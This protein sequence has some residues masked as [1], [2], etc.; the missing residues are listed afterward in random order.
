[1]IKSLLILNIL[2]LVNNLVTSQMAKLEIEGAIQIGN[3]EDPI[4][5]PGTIR[6]TGA[7]F[8]GWNGLSWVSL[9]GN[10]TVGSVTDIEGNTYRTIRVG[11]Q[12]WMAENLRVTRF[13]DNNSIEQIADGMIWSGLST[14][15]WCWY[16]NDQN[17]ELPY[18]KLYNWYAVATGKLCPT[19]WHV[20][21]SADWTTLIDYLGGEDIAGGKIK[22]TG[23][24]HWQSPNTGAT[25]ESSLTGLP[26][27]TRDE[28]GTY[29]NIGSYGIWWSSTASSISF[30]NCRILYSFGEKILSS[31][32][33]KVFGNSVRCLKD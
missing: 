18:G 13:S 14:P 28:N 17:Y 8:E 10:A 24:S 16:D 6:W 22:E 1:M 15:A 32:N 26:G 2:F 30:A 25:N 27:G 4:P 3:L 20:P 5:H 12:E 29:V 21:T 7:D 19:G 11:D 23:L 31:G 9:T 33:S